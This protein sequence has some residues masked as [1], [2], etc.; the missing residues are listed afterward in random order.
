MAYARYNRGRKKNKSLFCTN[1]GKNGHEWRDCGVPTTSWGVILVNINSEL[2]LS[3]NAS[4]GPIQIYSTLGDYSAYESAVSIDNNDTDR[5]LCSTILDCISFL[6]ISRKHSLAYVEF[7]RGRYKAEKPMQVAYLF[8]LMSSEEIQKI[9]L[10]LK[11]DEGF[12]YLWKDMWGNKADIPALEFNKK[13]AKSKYNMLRHIGVDGP[14]IGLDFMVNEVTVQF[15]I[16]EWGFPKGRRIRDETERDCAIREFMEE[17]G[18]EE[19]DFKII[20]EIDPLI[21]EFYGTDGAKYRH[22][23]YVAELITQKEPKNDIT[24]S[25]KD[26]VGEITFMNLNTATQTIRPYHKEKINLITS[27][28]QYYFDTVYEA[29]KDLIDVRTNQSTNQ[30][31]NQSDNHN[32]SHL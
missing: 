16:D 4:N 11:M 25:Q 10:S 20:D 3:H 31:D 29:V 30:S 15:D 17:S 18:Y 14:E 19:S 5:Y 21:E 23:Y 7:I 13:E 9:K 2:P 26:E 24:E 1:C 32:V 8:K 27:L 28:T 6:M 22:V 12:D